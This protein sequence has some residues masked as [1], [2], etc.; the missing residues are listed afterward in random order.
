MSSPRQQ[1]ALLFRVP[2]VLLPTVIERLLPF[3]QALALRVTLVTAE[4]QRV[5]R[6]HIPMV[7]TSFLS[8][9]VDLLNLVRGVQSC[10][11]RLLFHR[12]FAIYVRRSARHHFL[13]LCCKHKLA[14]CSETA[15]S[16]VIADTYNNV[17]R[18]VTPDG[19]RC[20][21]PHPTLRAHVCAFRSACARS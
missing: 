15:G 17:V 12:T 9:P 10:I 3:V 1:S 6:S 5:P 16:V 7:L 11:E 4:L 20:S 18:F 14:R 8:V 19:V 13:Q 2:H 21:I